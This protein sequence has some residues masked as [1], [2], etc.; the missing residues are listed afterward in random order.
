MRRHLDAV[1]KLVP[2]WF[3]GT[4]DGGA[5]YH[6]IH[7]LAG[8]LDDRS[9]GSQG[10]EPRLELWRKSLICQINRRESHALFFDRANNALGFWL[11]VL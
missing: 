5:A 8:R 9:D 3:V 1:T 4:R 10:R 2:C 6:F 11:R 7:D